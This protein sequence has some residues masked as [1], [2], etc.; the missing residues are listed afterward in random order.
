MLPHHPPTT[1]PSDAVY[2]LVTYHITEAPGR[3]DDHIP[4]GSVWYLPASLWQFIARGFMLCIAHSDQ[5][6]KCDGRGI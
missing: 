5:I 2:R 6:E 4:Y 1:L 3:R